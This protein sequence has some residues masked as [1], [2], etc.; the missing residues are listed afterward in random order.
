MKDI[1]TRLEPEEILESWY[2]DMDELQDELN[3]LRRKVAKAKRERK[4][5]PA[6]IVKSA[7]QGEYY[8][9]NQ[10]QLMRTND[11]LITMVAE[12]RRKATPEEIDALQKAQQE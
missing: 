6:L 4:K 3:R 1:R 12:S 9:T 10:Y 8:V 7:I 11:G 5:Q 2:W